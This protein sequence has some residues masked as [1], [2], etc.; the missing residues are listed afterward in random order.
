MLSLGGGHS[1]TRQEGSRETACSPLTFTGKL[2]IHYF[3]S[4]YSSHG[5]CWPAYAEHLLNS[6]C[7][8]TIGCY[9]R[10]RCFALAKAVLDG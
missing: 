9:V 7:Y 5:V 8:F 2:D 3:G 10:Q 6:K 4:I 1:L